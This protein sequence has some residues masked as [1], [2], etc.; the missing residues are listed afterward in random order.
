MESGAEMNL[1]VRYISQ[2]SDR[3]S[4]DPNNAA[5]TLL[6]YTAPEKRETTMIL[7]YSWEK[8]LIRVWLESCFIIL[9]VPTLLQKILRL[10]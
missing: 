3:S 4:I 9:M 10:A 7:G 5:S 6:R 1:D 8:E 2:L